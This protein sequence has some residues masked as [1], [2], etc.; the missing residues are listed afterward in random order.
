[1]IGSSSTVDNMTLNVQSHRKD[2][3]AAYDDVVNS[4]NCENWLV[5]C[6]LEMIEPGD[7]AGWGEDFFKLRLKDAFAGAVIVSVVTKRSSI[8]SIRIVLAFKGLL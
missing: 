7:A 2:I 3:L 6:D 5:N 1:M 4:P 8:C